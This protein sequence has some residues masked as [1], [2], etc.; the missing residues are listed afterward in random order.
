MSDLTHI[1]RGYF[2]DDDPVPC[3]LAAV[4]GE[5]RRPCKPL[6]KCRCGMAVSLDLHHVH[7]DGRV[8]NSFLH[9]RPQPEACGWHV[10][11]ILDGWIGLEFP[12]EPLR[13]IQ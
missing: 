2:N 4:T 9:D 5:D 11:L 6:I 13:G 12:P 7:T 10:F 3:W 8:T 1:P